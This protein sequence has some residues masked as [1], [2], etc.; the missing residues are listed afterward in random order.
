MKRT[1]AIVTL[2]WFIAA[3][4][5]LSP[6][7]ERAGAAPSPIPLLSRHA[8]TADYDAIGEYL[9][10]YDGSRRCPRWTLHVLTRQTLRRNG[11][12][13]RPAF[14]PDDL[15]PAESRAT[16]ADYEMSGFDKGHCVAAED[17]DH[18]FP[19]FDATFVLSN[20][21]PQYPNCNRGC[22]KVLE[23]SVRRLAMDDG[24]ERV[25][26][27]T[28][29]AW[30]ADPE[31]GTARVTS[32][33][34]RCIGRSMIHVPTHCVK[35]CLLEHKNGG[36]EIQSWIVP[37]REDVR[38]DPGMYRTTLTEVRRAIGLEAW[39]GLEDAEAGK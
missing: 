25:F 2:S 37:N 22:W 27:L 5:A 35:S 24:V 9:R 16:N 15:A 26:V 1:L 3:L 38:G 32:L 4:A 34:V 18:S 21:I 33:R 20:V 10:S 23:A 11:N 12:H 30:I 13:E 39:R 36:R 7:D 31:Q 17:M 8:P 28:A 6:A 19:A 29:P 14:R